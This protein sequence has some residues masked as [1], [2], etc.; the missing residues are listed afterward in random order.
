M[1]E[2]E[3]ERKKEKEGDCKKIKEHSKSAFERQ[4]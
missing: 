2:K 4:W 3:R 1:V